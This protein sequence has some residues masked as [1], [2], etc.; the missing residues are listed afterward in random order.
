MPLVCGFESRPE[1][2]FKGFTANCGEAFIY[3][4]FQHLSGL[5]GGS[6]GISK[7]LKNKISAISCP[8][9]RHLPDTALVWLSEKRCRQTAMAGCRSSMT[10]AA[11]AGL[12]T[13]LSMASAAA[14]SLK[15]KK[16]RRRHGQTLRIL[17]AVTDY[18]P[19]NTMSASITSI[20]R[21]SASVTM[22]TCA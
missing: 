2:H 15:P 14:S 22:Q 3:A 19:W 8:P 20:R 11:T 21:Q 17:S 6:C 12:W 18:G 10:P 9:N 1:H 16:R 7:H 5:Y 4:D 13:I